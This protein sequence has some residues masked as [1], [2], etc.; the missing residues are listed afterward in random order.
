MATGA[1]S[2]SPRL[3]AIPVYDPDAYNFMTAN[4][5]PGGQKKVTIVKVLGFFIDKMQGNDV[6]GW[7]TTYP[8]EANAGMGGVPGSG[9]VVSVA[10]VR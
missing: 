3:V 10:L 9:F 8:A 6:A 5:P 7:I 2:I 1:C 4:T